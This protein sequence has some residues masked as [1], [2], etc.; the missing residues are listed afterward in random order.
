MEGSLEIGG[1]DTGHMVWGLY[2]S[3]Y[4]QHLESLPQLY[5][6]LCACV[7]GWEHGILE[8]DRGQ[9]AA[10]GSLWPW[11]SRG[12]Q[13]FSLGSRLLYPLSLTVSSPKQK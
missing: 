7:G 4:S 9:L 5:L 6:S 10:V 12:T 11:M 3:V 2:V 1:K 8:E 13:V